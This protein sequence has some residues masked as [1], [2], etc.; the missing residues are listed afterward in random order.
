ML[1]NKPKQKKEKHFYPPKV[2]AVHIHLN[3]IE[4]SQL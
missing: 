4:I 1:R 2:V 3:K